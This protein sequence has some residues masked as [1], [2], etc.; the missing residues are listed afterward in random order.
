MGIKRE[1]IVSEGLLVVAKFEKQKSQIVSQETI[2][3]NICT[4]ELNR[5]RESSKELKTPSEIKL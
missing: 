1:N 2:T 4:K 3:C 5:I